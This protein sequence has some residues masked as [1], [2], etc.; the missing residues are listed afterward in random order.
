MTEQAISPLVRRMIDGLK[1]HFSMRDVLKSAQEASE[2]RD[3]PIGRLAA[4]RDSAA[5]KGAVVAV[6]QLEGLHH[7]Y[8]QRA[9]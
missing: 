4:T 8:E 9:A 2:V 1:V 6:S 3:S 7:R 5:R